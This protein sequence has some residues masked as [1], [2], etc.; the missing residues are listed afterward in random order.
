[1]RVL[2]SK[3]PTEKICPHCAAVMDPTDPDGS[4]CRV[5][6][7]HAC[8][9]KN[10]CHLCD[11]RL[12]GDC[13]GHVIDHLGANHWCTQDVA[14]KIQ[15]ISMLRRLRFFTKLVTGE[16]RDKFSFD[17][18]GD[19]EFWNKDATFS[20]VDI[21][22]SGGSDDLDNRKSRPIVAAARQ[23]SPDDVEYVKEY[24]VSGL[25]SVIRNQ[26]VGMSEKSGI[27][28]TSEELEQV[29]NRTN[30]NLFENIIAGDLLSEQHMATIDGGRG[31]KPEKSQE[32]ICSTEEVE[33]N[34]LLG[35]FGDSATS[36][37]EGEARRNRKAFLQQQR[38]Q[39]LTGREAQNNIQPW[40]AAQEQTVGITRIFMA[41]EVDFYYVY[42][43]GDRDTRTR[44][45]MLNHYVK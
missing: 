20:F 32:K 13:H 14:E 3:I 11:F 23:L 22:L 4:G 5:V 33:K 10:I 41:L 27:I 15:R 39:E 42:G 21:L 30:E 38:R 7:C 19:V 18:E 25:E 37:R 17:S 9:T 16:S 44:L 29:L 1:M 24:V 6:T 36:S 31:R 43:G 45:Q 8:K 28:T 26:F 35:L 34:V 12:S 40:R 2:S